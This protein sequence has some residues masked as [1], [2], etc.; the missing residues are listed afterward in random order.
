[1]TDSIKRFIPLFKWILSGGLAFCV[2]VTLLFIL[3]EKVHLYYLFAVTLAFLTSAT[4]NY[5]ISGLTIFRNAQHSIRR[6]YTTFM[7]VSLVGL[8][9]ITVSMYIFVEIF[10]IH[11]LLSRFILAATLG[12]SSFFVHKYF[13]FKDI[14]PTSNPKEI[15]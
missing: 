6:S 10:H 3:V 4:L 11:Y 2:D 15:Q 12:V 14:A 8:L 5:T 1:M 13:S 9:C 7:S